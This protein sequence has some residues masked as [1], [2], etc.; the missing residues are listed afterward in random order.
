MKPTS[1][2]INKRMVNCKEE[3]SIQLE[4][5]KNS[6]RMLVLTIKFG[7]LN[8]RESNMITLR[9]VSFLT[10]SNVMKMYLTYLVMCHQISN[11][12]NN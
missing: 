5:E 11:I 2:Q 1:F 7:K 9:F 6:I 8:F 12:I 3:S 4:S 10:K